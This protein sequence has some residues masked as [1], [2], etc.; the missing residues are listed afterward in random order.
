MTATGCL[1]SQHQGCWNSSHVLCFSC[2]L[3][4]MPLHLWSASYSSRGR[5]VPF[6]GRE[7]G[8]PPCRVF[9]SMEGLVGYS[10][11]QV[12]RGA[13]HGWVSATGCVRP[14][15]W[16]LCI[17]GTCRVSKNLST[18]SS[19]IHLHDSCPV[20][21]PASG[22]VLAQ[23]LLGLGRPFLGGRAPAAGA[24]V[25]PAPGEVTFVPVP[26]GLPSSSPLLRT[27]LST[28]PR[29]RC[30]PAGQRPTPATSPTPGTGRMR[31]S[32]SRS[33]CTPCP[34]PSQASWGR[35]FPAGTALGL[36]ELAGMGGWAG[37]PFLRSMR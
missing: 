9:V 24:V 18:G 19:W 33:E 13:V 26:Q 8:L 35:G 1:E 11:G 30:S 27:S 12:G 34:E 32:T 7:S 17:L 21:L 16:T 3:S 29:T 2:L 37:V 14:H 23:S 4:L 6:V 36:W 5:L 28:S 31:M 10:G 25:P 15:F 20:V 22:P